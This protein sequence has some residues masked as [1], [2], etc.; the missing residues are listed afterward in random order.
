MKTMNV[1]LWRAIVWAALWMCPSAMALVPDGNWRITGD[2]TDI[3]F[4]MIGK[5]RTNTFSVEGAYQSDRFL[6]KINPI[7]TEEEIAETVG[8]DGKKLR[9]LKRFPEEPGKGLPRDRARGIVEPTVFARYAIHA[10][11]GLLLGLADTN[12]LMYLQALEEPVILGMVRAYPEEEN[13]YELKLLLDG[14]V[15]ITALTPGRRIT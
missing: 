5:A 12:S 14:S 6:V 2:V 13:T 10:T 1:R 9:L 3:R 8:W 11:A 15:G 7:N 4:N